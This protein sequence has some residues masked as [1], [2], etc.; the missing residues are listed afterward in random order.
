MPRY[1]DCPY[2]GGRVELTGEREAYIRMRHPEALLE[3]YLADTLAQ[4][5]LIQPDPNHRRTLRFT[6]WYDDLIGGKHLIVVVVEDVVGN[7][8]WI[9]TVHAARKP[10]RGAILWQR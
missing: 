10:R 3:R 5:D 4:P 1:F 9:V 2:L 7:R 8:P 6:R